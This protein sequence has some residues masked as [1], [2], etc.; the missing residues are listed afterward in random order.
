MN[1]ATGGAFSSGFKM[2]KTISAKTLPGLKRQGFC[3]TT[4]ATRLHK[5]V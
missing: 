5:L 4:R 3:F 2:I 1:I